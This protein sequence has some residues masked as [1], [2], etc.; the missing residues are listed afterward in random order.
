[1]AA[2]A[3]FCGSSTQTRRSASLTR[4]STSTWWAT[5]VESWSG[6]SSSTSPLSPR[7]SRGSSSMLSRITWCRF[8]TPSQSSSSGAPSA[9]QAHAMVQE[10]VGRRTPIAASSRPVTALNVEDFP[11]PVA[12]ASATIVWS[13]ESRSRSP[14]RCATAAASSTRSSSSL[15]RA[16]RA[17]SASPSMRSVTSEPRPTSLLAP[18]TSA[19]TARPP[20]RGREPCQRSAGRRRAGT[21]P[22]GRRRRRRGCR[23]SRAPRGSGLAPRPS[24]RSPAR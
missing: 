9:P 13:P 5:S 10:V 15:P 2:S 22:A 20:R 14:A 11:E 16:D 18:S 7:S 6:R 17:A 1:M 24:A 3:Y 21:P 19:L 4:R 23:G 8:G 12:P